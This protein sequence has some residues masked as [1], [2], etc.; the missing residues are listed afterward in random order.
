[1]KKNT[2]LELSK[3]ITQYSTLTL[4]IAAVANASG[5]GIVHTVVPDPEQAITDDEFRINFNGD[6]PPGPAEGIHEFAL[7]AWDHGN[8]GEQLVIYVHAD[9][10]ALGVN[11]TY[12]NYPFALNSGA[13][14]SSGNANWQGGAGWQF[15]NYTN[16]SQPN[17]CGF[18]SDNGWCSGEDKF[19]GLKF[20]IDRTGT[21][22]Y[23]GWAKV[24]IPDPTDLSTWFVKEYA[25]NSTPGGAINAGQTTLSVNGNDFASKVRIVALD[26]TIGLYN[27]PEKTNYKLFSM[28]GQEILKGDTQEN[29][30]AIDTKVA[31]GIYIMELED[32]NTKAIM[33]KKV[34]L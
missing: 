21:D 29:T 25:Y 23:Y 24:N 30:H 6:D 2:S 13:I 3:R 22:Y 33:R 15:L 14:I 10:F 34:V 20:K 32:A 7:N 4:A 17:G 31:S 16:G 5:Q 27:L 8:G 12:G 28:T 9:S 18:A 11:D 1:M 26:K 19:I